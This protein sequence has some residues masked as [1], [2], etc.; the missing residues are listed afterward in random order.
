VD[1]TNIL[2][3]CSLP[4]STL[5]CSGAMSNLL[6]LW[7]AG[8][9]WWSIGVYEEAMSLTIE[10]WVVAEREEVGRDDRG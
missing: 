9:S 6:L 2:T 4:K 10:A 5:A 1:R 8:F 7:D 3:W